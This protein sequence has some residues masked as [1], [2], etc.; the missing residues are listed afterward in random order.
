MQCLSWSLIT[1]F[2]SP[3]AYFYPTFFFL[4]IIHRASRDIAR[5][6]EKYGADWDEYCRICP[7]LFIPVCYNVVRLR[8]NNAVC[9]LNFR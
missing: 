7:Y 2:S 3:I 6:R 1:G 5:C 4:M 8:A 9:V